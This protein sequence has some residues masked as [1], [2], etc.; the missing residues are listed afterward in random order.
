VLAELLRA[1]EEAYDDDAHWHPLA[2]WYMDRDDPRGELIAIDLAL[3]T[4]LARG[5]RAELDARRAEILAASAP[6]LLGETFARVI[7]DDYARVTWRRGFI[8]ELYFVGDRTMRHRRQCGWLLELMTAQHEPFSLLRVLDLAYTDFADARLLAP[9]PH[10][11]TVCIYETEVRDVAA[12]VEL[13]RLR[14]V[15]LSLDE[16]ALPPLRAAKRVELVR[17]P[18]S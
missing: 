6:K 2:D 1:I 10:L 9:F 18:L 17:T 3:E 16:A 8:D 13:P 5:K 12:L 14:R 7:A 11:T 4:R 15:H